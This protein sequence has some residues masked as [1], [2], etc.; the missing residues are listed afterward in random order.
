MRRTISYIA[1]ILLLAVSCQEKVA[2]SLYGKIGFRLENAPAVE[3]GTKASEEADVNDFM[4]Y[5]VSAT[6][7]FEYV[8]RDIVAAGGVVTIPVGIYTVSAEN[9]SEEASVLQ[10]DKWGQPR[11]AAVTEPTPVVPGDDPVQ[12]NLVCRMTNAAVRVTFDDNIRMKYTDYKVVV[13]TSEER[14]LDFTA[15]NADSAVGYFLPGTLNFVFT[16]TLADEG[17]EGSLN[18]TVELS[19]ATEQYLNFKAAPS[20]GTLGIDV[21]V[22]TR[23]EPVYEDVLIDPGK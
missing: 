15:E 11:Y 18:G 13:Y 3:I 12:F 1:A 19:A 22:D 21:T 23:F 2:D 7:K 16:G 4:V 17:V 20:P 6:S 14:K 9:V 8:Y 10:P 5:G